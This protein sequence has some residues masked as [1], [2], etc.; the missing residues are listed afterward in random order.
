MFSSIVDFLLQKFK[1][2]V[3]IISVKINYIS[4]NVLIY[5]DVKKTC[6]KDVLDWLQDLRRLSVGIS[7]HFL[8]LS[9]PEVE[10]KGRR[11]L[12][13]F[14]EASDNGNSLDKHL[15]IPH[16]IWSK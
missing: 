6:E 5:Y 11:L 15:E 12:D 8:D 14:K 10:T 13:F 4:G 3:G 16:D 1:L 7:G 2:P 9:V